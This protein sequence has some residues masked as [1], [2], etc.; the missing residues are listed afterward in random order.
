MTSKGIP[1]SSLMPVQKLAVNLTLRLSFKNE[2]LVKVL[3]YIQ[4]T[5]LNLKS[6]GFP[7]RTLSPVQRYKLSAYLILVPCVNV[8]HIF[9][10]QPQLGIPACLR[11]TTLQAKSSWR[12]SVNTM[13]AAS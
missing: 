12:E 2:H 7:P 13:P 3:L 4:R 5:K 9:C 11:P 8:R 1:V 10:L 6:P